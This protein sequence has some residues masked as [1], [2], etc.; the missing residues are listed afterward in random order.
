[1]TA[2]GASG[3]GTAPGTAPPASQHWDPQ[4]YAATAGFVA[5]L[6]EPLLDLLKPVAGRRVLD[7]GCGDGALTTKLAELGATVVGVD[8]SPEQVAA[9]LA[10]GLDAR[11]MDGEALTFAAEF[12]AVLSN[13]ALHWMRRPDAVIDGVWRALKPGGRFVAEMGGDGNVRR[14]V[15]ALVAALD[16]RGLDGRAAVPWYFPTV[17]DYRARLE[18]RGFRVDA[19]ELFERTTPL[20]GAIT[21]WLRTFGESFTSRLPAVERDAYLAEVSAALAPDLRDADGRWRAD[22]VRL[23]VVATRP[24]T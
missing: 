13:A 6:G 20:P 5:V 16:Q 15:G 4:R 24:A 9:A 21:D 18:A 7:L 17:A 14:I 2:A 1:V 10:R 8:A 19:I 3:K 23:R 11:V 22:Y 12:D